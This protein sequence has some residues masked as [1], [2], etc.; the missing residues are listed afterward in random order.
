MKNKKLN[1]KKI[2]DLFLIAF[3]LFFAMSF[4]NIVRA[5]TMIDKSAIPGVT[6]PVKGATP[7]T[8][9]TATAQYTGTVTWSP[10][11]SPFWAATTYTAT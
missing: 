7:V 6:P 3:V 4:V 8:T 10:T 11:H 9:I 2:I 5:D 1:I